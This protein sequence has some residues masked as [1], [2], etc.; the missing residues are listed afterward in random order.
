MSIH[1]VAVDPIGA[2]SLHAVDFITESREIGSQNGWGDDDFLHV[3]RLQ[4]L[5]RLQAAYVFR[6]STVGTLVTM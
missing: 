4:G 5:H 6:S 2:C 1:D 3:K